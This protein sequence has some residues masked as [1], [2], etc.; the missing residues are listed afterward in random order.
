MKKD[1]SWHQRGYKETLP[2]TLYGLFDGIFSG[3]KS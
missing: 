3:T 1:F 2:Y